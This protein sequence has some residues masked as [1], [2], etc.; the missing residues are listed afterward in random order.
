MTYRD[1]ARVCAV[2]CGVILLAGCGSSSSKTT[3]AASGS[4]VASPSATPA[5]VAQ[6]QKIVLQPSDLPTGW[7]GAPFKANPNQVADQA[8]LVKC[9][10]ARNTASDKVAEMH[11]EDFALRDARISSSAS[12][13]RSPS[14]IDADLVMMHSPKLSSCFDQLMKRT[15]ATTMPTGVKI[16]SSSIKITPGSAGG[17]A[18]VVAT[19]TGSIEVSVNGQQ[20]PFFVSVAYITGPLIEAEVDTFNAGSPVPASVVNPLVATVATRASKGA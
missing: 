4:P 14:D 3:P 5:S 18:N 15:L 13:Y 9:V 19:G 12:T 6:L 1:L 7:K 17:P 8:S 20:V 10:G 16:A 11:S 2:G